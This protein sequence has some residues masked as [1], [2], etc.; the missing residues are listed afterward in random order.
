[1]FAANEL[2][3]GPFNAISL[4]IGAININGGDVT[5]IGNVSF[6]GNHANTSGGKGKFE[7][8]LSAIR[9]A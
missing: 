4:A 7:E 3:L 9:G 8:S 2:L 5:F 6:D 1:M